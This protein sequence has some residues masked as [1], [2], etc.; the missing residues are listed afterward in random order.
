MLKKIF[1]ILFLTII[2]TNAFTDSIKDYVC[3]VKGNLSVENQNFLNQYKDELAKS[4]F[5]RYS[6]YIESFL[7]ASRE[8]RRSSLRV[9]LASTSTAG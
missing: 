5:G 2:S 9:P 8:V 6:D 1:L 4:G 3:V 7:K